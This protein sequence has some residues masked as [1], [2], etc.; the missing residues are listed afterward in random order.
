MDYSNQPRERREAAERW[1]AYERRSNIQV[2]ITLVIFLLIGIGANLLIRVSGVAKQIPD[3]YQVKEKEEPAIELK[4]PD[5]AI[6]VEDWKSFAINGVTLSLG[7]SVS[8][9]IAKG[10]EIKKMSFEDEDAN[11][12][13]ETLFDTL[14]L[15]KDGEKL[16]AITVGAPEDGKMAKVRDCVLTSV[17][18]DYYIDDYGVELCGGIRLRT[19]MHYNDDLENRGTDPAFKRGLYKAADIS[20]ALSAYPSK[21]EGDKI[22]WYTGA[23]GDENQSLTCE[24]M[25]GFLTRADLKDNPY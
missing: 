5:T 13:A 25:D 12:E 2:A 21:T 14:Y 9:C 24:F 3:R 22:I 4:Y 19:M 20:N 15:A 23:E 10:F 1:R 11:L 16:A 6:P 8:S 7:E 17:S 18:L